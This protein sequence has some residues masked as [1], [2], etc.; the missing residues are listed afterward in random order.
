MKNKIL[1]FLV[2]MHLISLVSAASTNVFG[3]VGGQFVERIFSGILW[4]GLGFLV[5]G[6]LGFLMWWFLIYKKKFNIE[7]KIMSKRAKNKHNIL[8]DTAAIL[9]D[10]KDGSKY[11]SLWKTKKQLPL[12]N[13]NILQTTDKGDYMELYRTGEDT[14]YFLLPSKIDKRYLVKSDGGIIPVAEQSTRLVDPNMD[15]WSQKRKSLNKGMFDPEKLWMK[16]LPF[17]P[18]ILAGV[19]TIFTL[20]VLMNYLPDILSQLSEL[21]S[22]LKSTTAAKVTTGLWMGLI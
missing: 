2:G 18:Q 16:I 8:F 15:F 7:V 9:T 19:F 5:L 21:A 3:E 13:F 1:S 4:F 10:R 11:F 17:I 20:W 22:T 14:F 6:V 12:P